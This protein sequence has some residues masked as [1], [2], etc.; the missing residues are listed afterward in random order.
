MKTEAQ[1]GRPSWGGASWGGAS[2][3]ER[4]LTTKDQK[5]SSR[6]TPHEG[7][8]QIYASSAQ[9]CVGERIRPADGVPPMLHQQGG[10]QLCRAYIKL[11][12]GCCLPPKN[13]VDGAGCQRRTSAFLHALPWTGTT[14]LHRSRPPKTEDYNCPSPWLYCGNPF[15]KLMRGRRTSAL[16]KEGRLPLRKEPELWASS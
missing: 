3:G 8:D 11:C 15:P 13:R 7:R 16:K 1:Q 10:D 5:T 6:G 12:G 2:W 14:A 9:S 4:R